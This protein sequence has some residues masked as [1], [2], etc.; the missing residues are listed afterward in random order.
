MVEKGLSLLAPF[1][2]VYTQETQKTEII[3]MIPEQESRI[4]FDFE[5]VGNCGILFVLDEY[6][7]LFFL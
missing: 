7:L 1:S 6:C 3:T 2:L 4:Q 5:D